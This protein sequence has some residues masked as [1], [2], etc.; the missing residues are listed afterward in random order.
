VLG[1]QYLNK[2]KIILNCP[3]NVGQFFYF[4]KKIS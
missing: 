2:N 4:Y 3:T 1:R